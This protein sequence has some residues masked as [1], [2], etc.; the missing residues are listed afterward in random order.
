MSESR[1]QDQR[2]LV[3]L[4]ALELEGARHA[5]GDELGHG[6]QERE[7]ARAN[8]QRALA[9]DDKYLPALNQLAVY[10]LDL[11]RAH[12][13]AHG[14]ALSRPS[15]EQTQLSR[16]HLELASLVVERALEYD[17]SY[18]PLCNTEGVIQV[19]L[20]NFTAAGDPHRLGL[21]IEREF[22]LAAKL[23]PLRPEVD[24]N[25]ARF[26]LT[27]VRTAQ[28]PAELIS[29]TEE[30]VA[31]FRRFVEKASKEPRFAQDVAKAREQVA[32]LKD[33]GPFLLEGAQP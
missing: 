12:A 30:A 15:S 31:A 6:S 28:T 17:E 32:D 1:Y 7:R 20:G 24:Y 25:R 33:T 11:A 14:P 21:E 4:A 9:I 5:S 26:A 13:N 18:A 10:Y 2:A 23:E 22:A 8:L 16:R 3:L 19:E 27:R 29:T